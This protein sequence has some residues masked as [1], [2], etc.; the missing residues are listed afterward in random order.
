MLIYNRKHADLWT[1]LAPPAIWAIHFLVCYAAAAI[2]C[3][4]AEDIFAGLGGLRILIL[5]VTLLAL[6]LIAVA[7]LQA[8][9]HWGFGTDDPPYEQPTAD[10]R[11]HF[12]GYATLL[13]CA[14]SFVSVV[15][16]ALPALT[17]ADCR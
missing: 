8:R 12:L 10:V 2:A 9:R 11:Q 15:F 14:L 13:L 1:L 5:V 4:K 3:A 16:V 6:A 7:G 17:I